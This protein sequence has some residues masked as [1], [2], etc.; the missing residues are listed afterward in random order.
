M[1]GTPRPDVQF[2]WAA[3]RFA[4]FSVHDD[5]TQPAARRRLFAVPLGELAGELITKTRELLY[6][7]FDGVQV[8]PAAFW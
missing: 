7:L 5:L 8:A 4:I 2:D 1:P 6:A 3:I